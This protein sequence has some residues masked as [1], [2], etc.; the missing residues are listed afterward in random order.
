M[1]KYAMFMLAAMLTIGLSVSAQN[2]QRK[3]RNHN[4]NRL[5]QEMRMTAKERAE[6]MAKQLELTADQTEKVQALLEKQD[7]KRIEQITKFREQR[8]Q[9]IT[10]R[11]KK[12]EE[13][14]ALREN[15]MKENRAELESI[16]GKEKMEKLNSLRESR[17]Q[18]PQADRQGK[19]TEA[20]KI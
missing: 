7:A 16:I 8:E 10:N 20:S 17:Q 11:D 12:R 1:K 9:A 15:E 5:R 13:M 18:R 2:G 3:Q 4:D 14:H 19:K 6:W